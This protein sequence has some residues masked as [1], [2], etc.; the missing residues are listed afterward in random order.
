M[1]TRFLFWFQV[2]SP[3]GSLPLQIY[4]IKILQWFLPHLIEILHG[5]SLQKISQPHISSPPP[6][7]EIETS[8]PAPPPIAPSNLIPLHPITTR[9]H[10]SILKPNP[11]YALFVVSPYTP[12]E[13][14]SIKTFI[15][16]LGWHAAMLDE[17]RALHQN[18]TWVLVPP[19]PTM[20]I[21]GCRWIFK[22][23]VHLDG[24]LDRLKSHL[25]TKG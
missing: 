21:I 17:I 16:D 2:L 18:H 19:Q 13:P 24:S 1:C 5:F 23:K 25:V 11:K 6:S 14:K 20:N 12:M 7:T 15:R 8:P 3:N 22:T 4:L 9:S 10:L